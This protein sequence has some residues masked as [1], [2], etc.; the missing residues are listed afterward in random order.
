MF[1]KIAKGI[2]C[3]N[4]KVGFYNSYM[5]LP[6][7]GV[8]V[9]EVFM[10]Y[11]LNAPT[12]WAFEVTV[13]LFGVHY[14]L[15]FGYAHK[16][17]VHVNIDVIEKAL[18]PRTRLKLRIIT[19]ALMFLPTIGLIAIWACIQAYDATLV[20]D[21]A[22]STWAPRIWPFKIIMAIGF[23]LFWLQ[24]ISQIIKDVRELNGTAAT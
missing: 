4:E 12:I 18:K 14:S 10:R 8:I 2:D 9:F 7:L 3:L 20:N 21:M 24:G 13:F 6:L 16:Y 1:E 17:G 22:S 19:H 15:V 23:V 5:I 11:A